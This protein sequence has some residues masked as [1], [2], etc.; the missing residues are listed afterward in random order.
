M[1]L[2]CTGS[3]MSILISHCK[4]QTLRGGCCRHVATRTNLA[5]V[6]LSWSRGN[7]TL[8]YILIF[9]YMELK[10]GLGSKQ[11]LIVKQKKSLFKL[12]KSQESGLCPQASP[13][14]TAERSSLHGNSS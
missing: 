8:M 7:V 13:E 11:I 3:E 2:H 9:I 10:A 1:P 5:H 14:I 12:P 6:L 4:K